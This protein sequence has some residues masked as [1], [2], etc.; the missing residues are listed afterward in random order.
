M[1]KYYLLGAIIG[2]IA[3][4]LVP[5]WPLKILL[6]WVFFSLSAVS[7]AYIFHYPSLFRKR[8]DGTIP[9]YIRWIFIPFLLGTGAY[10]SWA[11]KHDKVPPIQQIKSSLFL[12]CRLS[13]RDVD[14]LK[15]QGVNAIVD[16]TAEFDA[17]DWSAQ[18][19]DCQYLN[20]P[21][22]DHTSPTPEQLNTAINWI[23]Q[24]IRDD[25]KVV[26]HCALGRG[27]SV[28]IVA[29]YLLAIDKTLSIEEAMS[30]IQSI[31]STARLNKKQL[32]ALTKIKQGGRIRLTQSLA[33]IANPVAG[34]G[35]WQDEKNHILALLN[36]HFRVTVLETT[37]DISAK[38][39]AMAA[40]ENGADILVA[41]G[42]D[43][44]VTEVASV[45]VNNNKTL[46]VIPLGTANALSQVLHG[47]RSRLLPI[48]T[49]CDVI[50]GGHKTTMDT[51][52]CNDEL[53]LMVV[54]LGFEQQMIS[55]ADRSEKNEG[56]QFA[57]LRGLWKAL[58]ANNT[59]SLKV[60]F[61]DE[62]QTQ[63]ISTPSFVIA[64]AAPITTA[65]A[66]GGEQP[67]ITDGKADITW[68]HPQQDEDSQLLSL[69]ELVLADKQTK[70]ASERIY[71]K[72]AQT[73]KIELD[74]KTPYAVDGE[75]REA[76]V[77]QVAITKQNLQVLTSPD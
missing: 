46:A 16:V 67:N 61:D 62:A 30:Q 69:A 24:Q 17:L 10:N 58:S 39:R 50:T 40:V 21:I 14:T 55:S 36:P 64:N 57:Y 72:Q 37:Q 32:A 20:V 38:Q 1:V 45:C 33:V 11:R 18:Q 28:L 76:K 42:G 75:I 53:V 48:Q 4:W 44:T 54:A 6:G 51:A 65:L 35:K 13:T 71:H 15:Q 34:G 73:I 68:L 43:G 31:R 22:L 8:K 77:I 66:Q 74:K 26:V 5:F 19:M 23:D 29:A 7:F 25:R 60:T 52:I 27:R 49:A 2:A 70:Q 41:C 59:M 3:T 12:A 56:G 63:D 9:F 47:Y